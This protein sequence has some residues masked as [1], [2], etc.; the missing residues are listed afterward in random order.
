MGLVGAHQATKILW[1]AV[2]DL[3]ASPWWERC[4]VLQEVV[5]SKNATLLC[6]PSALS[7]EVFCKTFPVIFSM[8]MTYYRA[9]KQPPECWN[10]E[11]NSMLLAVVNDLDVMCDVLSSVSLYIFKVYI[12]INTQKLWQRR[13]VDLKGL[14]RHAQSPKVSDQRDRVY[15]CLGM[16]DPGYEIVPDYN[17][18]ASLA[19]VYHHTCRQI[20]LYE[21]C[22][23]ILC[24][25]DGNKLHKDNAL[26]SWVTTFGSYG[27]GKNGMWHDG[28]DR[29][30]GREVFRASSNKRAVPV[31][32]SD[33][34]LRVEC[35][36]IDQVAS[37]NLLLWIPR[38]EDGPN[39][40]LWIWWQ[41]AQRGA[42]VKYFTYETMKRA[43]DSLQLLSSSEE[44]D[45]LEILSRILEQEGGEENVKKFTHENFASA[46]GIW[47]QIAQPAAFGMGDP[48]H[49]P[50]GK[51]FWTTVFRGYSNGFEENTT[52]DPEDE[53]VYWFWRRTLL[54]DTLKSRSAFFR[55]PQGFIGLAHNQAKH[56]DY[57]CILLGASV[58]FVLRKIDDHYIFIGEAYIH[59]MMYGKAIEMMESG[60]LKRQTIDIH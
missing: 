57:L 45:D 18:A 21:Q 12:V 17:K 30:G 26:P 4:W 25:V 52:L 27:E 60:H 13:A 9:L 42:D 31:F 6:G 33:N 34:I 32:A 49:E 14:L 20:I 24:Y 28:I 1:T 59:G 29:P 2:R 35:L 36:I 23:D 44:V 5:V 56:T 11:E 3:M 15:A 37:D 43:V 8:Y 10:P 53:R 51:A 38:E 19:S 48:A 39:T 58:P 46:A 54:W 16:V 7:W 40:T 41:I 47:R 55:S 22:L 50:I